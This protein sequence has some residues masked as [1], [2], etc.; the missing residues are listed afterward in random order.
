MFP[1]WVMIVIAI[2]V[3]LI[4]CQYLP[5]PAGRIIQIVVAVIALLWGLSVLFGGGGFGFH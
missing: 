4:A 3:I 2:V 5:A 1:Q